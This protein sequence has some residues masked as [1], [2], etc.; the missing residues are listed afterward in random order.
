MRLFTGRH[1]LTVLALAASSMTS[2]CASQ[3]TAAGEAASAAR[4]QRRATVISEQELTASDA[5]NLSEAISQLRPRFLQRRGET[6]VGNPDGSGTVVYL[7]DTRIGG[8]EE[9][10]AIHPSDVREVRYLDGP[11]ASARYGMNHG[12]GAIM[13]YRKSGTKS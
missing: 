11:Q 7:D 6:S 13:V 2:G 8:I 4:I 12:G 10:R 5:T 9:L 1:W 3:S